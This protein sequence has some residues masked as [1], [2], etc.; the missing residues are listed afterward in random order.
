MSC[1]P[2][3][4]VRCLDAMRGPHGVTGLSV[5]PDGENS[6]RGCNPALTPVGTLVVDIKP[7]GRKVP[8]S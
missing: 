8:I 6:P 4:R 7:P 1:V 2:P 5:G 3:F